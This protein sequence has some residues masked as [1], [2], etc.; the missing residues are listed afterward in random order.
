MKV[1]AIFRHRGIIPAGVVTDTMVSQYDFL[2]RI[3]DCAGIEAEFQD[4]EK[5]PGCSF[6][7]TLRG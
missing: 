7:D 1:P 6:A 3:V 4:T 2:P 5:L